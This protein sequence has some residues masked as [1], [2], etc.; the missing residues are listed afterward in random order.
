MELRQLLKIALRWWWLIL[1][2]PLVVG[3]Y[4]LITYRA[5][6][7]TY[8]MTLRYTAGQ[9][10]ALS[11]DPAF[12]RNYYDWLTSE[13]IVGALKDWVRTGQFAE[14]V[15]AELAARGV[16][17]SPVAV[18]GAIE[19]SD[20]QRSILLVFL[21]GS[22]PEQL[23]ALAEAVTTVLQTKN[24]SVFPPLGG[25][26]A[27]VTALDAPSVGPAAP[28]SLRAWLDLPLRLALGLAAGVA[29]ALAAHYLDPFVRDKSDLEKQGWRVIA[30]IPRGKK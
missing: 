19:S 26:S 17:A 12:A 25:Q 1:L 13:Y 9:P 24:A 10:T 21:R 3:A 11:G 23:K 28:P 15:S 2:P 20:N 14:A 7:P 8:S 6:T 30:E 4:S 18:A 27:T 29:L 22:D 16:N 5:P